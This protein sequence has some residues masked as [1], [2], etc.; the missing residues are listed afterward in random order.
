MKLVLFPC[1][2][3]SYTFIEANKGVKLLMNEGKFKL[4]VVVRWK[5][6]NKCF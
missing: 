6:Y 1:T 2:D 3:V 4:M 5:I